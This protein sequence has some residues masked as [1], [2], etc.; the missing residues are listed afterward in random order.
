MINILKHAEISSK[1][2][3]SEYPPLYF[4]YIMNIYHPNEIEIRKMLL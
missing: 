2:G 1:S 4:N 3:A